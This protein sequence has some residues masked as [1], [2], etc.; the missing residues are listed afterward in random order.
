ME[1]VLLTGVSGFIAKH[2]AL[3]LLNAGYAVRGTCGGWT[4]PMRSAPPLPPT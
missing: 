3:K 2:V 4:A 1:L